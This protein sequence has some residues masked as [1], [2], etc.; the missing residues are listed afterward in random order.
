MKRSIK[1]IIKNLNTYLFAI[2]FIAILTLLLILEEQFSFQKIEIVKDEQ[3]IAKEL[4]Y[5]DTKN[6]ASSLIELNSKS[7]QL[8]QNINKLK[9]IHKY[10]FTSIYIL[11]NSKEYMQDLSLLS[12]YS[13]DFTHKL[14]EALLK[15]AQNNK[16]MKNSYYKLQA[17]LQNIIMKHLKY[18]Y[19]KYIITKYTTFFI[20]VIIAILTFLYR[21]ALYRIYEDISFLFQVDKDHTNYEIYSLEAD[22]I[23][24]RMNRKATTNQTSTAFIDQVTGINNYKGMLNSYS[25]KKHTKENNFTSVAVLEIDNFSKTKKPFSQEVVQAILKK[26]A[27]TISLYEEPADTIARTDYNQFTIILSRASK[28]QLFK[29]TDTIRESIAELKI[30]IPQIG[31]TQITVTGG[32]VVKPNH[33]S[34]ENA[35]KGAIDILKYA[36]STTKN[37][38]LRATDPTTKLK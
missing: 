15:D 36:Q 37:Q 2:F 14:H 18:D 31:T 35:I 21:R 10:N 13:T 29:D 16:D 28:E 24:L 38:I 26:V 34:L 8:Q 27:Y 9:L 6:K 3:K 5:L 30:N 4:F 7:A 25:S 23:A 17:E 12:K 32:F 11:N 20:F 33:S 22:A 19:E 1:N